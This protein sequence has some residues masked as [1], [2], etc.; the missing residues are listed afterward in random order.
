MVT[1]YTNFN[2]FPETPILGYV[3]SGFGDEYE[4][5]TNNIFRDIQP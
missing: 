3:F 2:T 4:Y 1:I 5:T